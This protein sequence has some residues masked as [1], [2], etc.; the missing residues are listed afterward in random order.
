MRFTLAALATWRLTHLVVVE[1]GPGRIVLRLRTRLDGSALAD[2]MDCFYCAS[3]W[4]AAAL[5]PVV[6]RRRSD[7]LPI[8]LALSGAACLLQRIAS[9]EGQSEPR[10]MGWRHP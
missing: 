8:S 3:V 4:V 9:D 10:D 7:V 2:L 5:T 6:A 1:D